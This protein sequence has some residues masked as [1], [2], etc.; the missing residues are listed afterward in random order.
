MGYERCEECKNVLVI[1]RERIA[2]WT[3]TDY[4]K[5]KGK[6]VGLDLKIIKDLKVIKQMENLEQGDLE[7]ENFSCNICGADIPES[8][9]DIILEEE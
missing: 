7:E 5:V 9:I 4:Y 1:K 6:I 8:L 3:Q 2:L